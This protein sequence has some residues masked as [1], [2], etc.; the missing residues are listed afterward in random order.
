MKKIDELKKQSK[1]YYLK[2]KINDKY[3]DGLMY[4]NYEFGTKKYLLYGKIQSSLIKTKFT[5]NEV[6][7]LRRNGVVP[8]ELFERI[9]V[10][11]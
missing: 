4:L 2:L 10:D 11:E 1:L 9:E 5:E 6:E 7:K 3:E 8:E